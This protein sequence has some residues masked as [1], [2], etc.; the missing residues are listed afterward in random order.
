MIGYQENPFYNNLMSY[1]AGQH[2]VF[3]PVALI[4]CSSSGISA[5]LAYLVYKYSSTLG[6]ELIQCTAFTWTISLFYFLWLPSE[7][8]N[9]S[10]GTTK[11]AG[12]INE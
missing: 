2:S 7:D 5:A 11:R 10:N 3:S 12:A 9:K 8:M 6:T 1:T 4:L